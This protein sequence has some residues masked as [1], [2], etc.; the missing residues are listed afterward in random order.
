MHRYRPAVLCRLLFLGVLLTFI[1]GCFHDDNPPTASAGRDQEVRLQAVVT[2]DGSNSSDVDGDKLT[3]K[4]EFAEK[5]TN[6]AATLLNPTTISPTFVADVPGSFLLKL[7]VSD[8]KRDSKP[9][10]VHIIT[11]NSPPSAKIVFVSTGAINE[12]VSLDASQST[13]P[14]QQPLFYLWEI[15]AKPSTSVATI[16]NPT[17][18][19]TG[20]IPDQPGYYAVKL[21][22]RDGQ[23]RHEAID[24]IIVDVSAPINRFNTKPI[25]EAGPDQPLRQAGATIT[26]DGS[27]SFDADNDP[28]T[29]SW[30]MIVKPENST[31]LLRRPDTATPEFDAD[32]M[33]S[34]VA[35]LTVA[36]RNGESHVDVVVITPHAYPQLACQDCHDG[37]IGRAKP[38]SHQPTLEDCVQCHG[39]QQWKPGVAGFHAHGHRTAPPGC[40]VCHDGTIATGMAANHLA[41]NDDCNYCHLPQAWKPI[42]PN[43]PIKPVVE[44]K[45]IY[46]GCVDCHNGTRALGK[47]DGHMPT[48][49]RCFACH[50]TATWKTQ[51]H[52][53]HTQAF[54]KCSNC[55]Q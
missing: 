53:E 16:E 30:T 23:D 20:F 44:H 36:D 7:V 32:I 45:G 31:A 35:K 18:I 12:R 33:G 43:S 48:S 9:D 41:T 1:T 37:N 39:A 46:S 19:N 17:S 22:V 6:S 55:H 38:A 14:E 15:S 51:Q 13:D 27:N 28:L 42:I 47:P 34:Y 25:A 29:Y 3:Y 40:R 2:L 54:G 26:L 24:I 50:T 52:L 4:W 10:F 5:P 49:I 11:A 21:G 8:G